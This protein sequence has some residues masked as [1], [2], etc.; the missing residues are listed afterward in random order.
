[1]HADSERLSRLITE[2][3]DVARIDTGRLPLYPRDIEPGPLV[4][5]ASSRCAPA[6]HRTVE[7]TYDETGATIFADPDKLSQVVTNL[8]DNA[9]RHGEG[10]VQRHRAAH[11]RRRSRAP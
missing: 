7:A 3:L 8:V 9:V 6:P 5:R 11:R 2:L 4:E 1:M 10:T